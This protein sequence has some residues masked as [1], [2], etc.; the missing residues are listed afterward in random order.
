MLDNL[1]HLSDPQ[2][3]LGI[4]RNCLR[5]PKVVYFLRTNTPSNEM[6]E[7]LKNFDDC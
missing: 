5:T 1:H 6:L 7:V 3:A 4:P 2:C